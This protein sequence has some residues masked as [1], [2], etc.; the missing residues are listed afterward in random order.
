MKTGVG[1]RW[2]GGRVRR[3]GGGGSLVWHDLD[4]GIRVALHQLLFRRLYANSRH[5]NCVMLDVVFS[6]MSLQARA[7]RCRYFFWLFCTVRK[8]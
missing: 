8:P 3:E 4:I 1:I 6:R 7:H 2:K 5:C